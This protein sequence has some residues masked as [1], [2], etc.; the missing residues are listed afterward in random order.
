M[1]KTRSSPSLQGVFTLPTFSLSSAPP[2]E[3]SGSNKTQKET[4]TAE[5][6]TVVETGMKPLSLK[7]RASCWG[8]KFRT[9][10]IDWSQEKS[11]QQQLFNEY[12]T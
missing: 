1:L 4:H 3:K 10:F 8:T 5:L 9:K 12:L 11:K 6:P 7:A 2:D